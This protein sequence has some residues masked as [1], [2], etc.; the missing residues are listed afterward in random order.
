MS[1][2]SQ[3]EHQLLSHKTLIQLIYTMKDQCG[4]FKYRWQKKKPSPRVGV[5][6][7]VRDT[8]RYKWEYWS[9]TGGSDG[10]F[11]HYAKTKKHQA[12]LVACTERVNCRNVFRLGSNNSSFVTKSC[13]CASDAFLRRDNLLVGGFF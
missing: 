13:A 11:C 2:A 6:G 10:Y 9:V 5:S 4:S 3:T 1:Y 8:V 12:F 7:A